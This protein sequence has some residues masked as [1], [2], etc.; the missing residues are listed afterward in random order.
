MCKCTP[1]IRTPF[2]GRGPCVDPRRHQIIV[3]QLVEMAKDLLMIDTPALLEL[4]DQAKATGAPFPVM[5]ATE[6]KEDAFYRML[7][8]LHAA[9]GAADDYRKAHVAELDQERAGWKAVARGV[10]VTKPDTIRSTMDAMNQTF[11][12][13]LERV[14]GLERGDIESRR[15]S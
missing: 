6:A 14:D 9:R 8:A 13:E 5:F 11:R 4:L 3:D 7:V 2:C 12:E 15:A 10:D 1:A